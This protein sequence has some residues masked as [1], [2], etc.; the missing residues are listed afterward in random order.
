MSEFRVRQLVSNEA[1]R[2]MADEGERDFQRAKQKARERL[3]FST[4][5]GLP[6]NNEID[7]ALAQR[8]SLFGVPSTAELLTE[9]LRHARQMMQLLN[10]F[11]PRLSGILIQ[12]AV[13]P[14]TP[15]E[16]HAFAPTP[17]ELL[18]FL[19]DQKIPYEVR[20]KRLR[21][22]LVCERRLP[23]VGVSADGIEV[24]ITVFSSQRYQAPPMSS[25]D[26]RPM[27]RLSLDAVN[28]WLT[29]QQR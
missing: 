17:D 22:S 5:I 10:Q 20:D 12:G 23:V 3:G 28:S 7:T 25:I 13:T 6:S 9:R 2:I 16:I 15:I 24:E 21:F 4:R 8:M 27:I 19:E 14:Y 11:A 1:A 18:G 26:G 29:A